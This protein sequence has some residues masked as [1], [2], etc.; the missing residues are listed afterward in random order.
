[1]EK[2]FA[3]APEVAAMLELKPRAIYGGEA[4]TSCLQKK[5]FGA[6]PKWYIPQVKA[7]LRNVLLE[8]ACDGS[9]A[10]VFD[11]IQQPGEPGL[12]LV[13]PVEQAG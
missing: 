5:Y 4:G 9:C 1:M 13:P 6:S 7:H 2:Q 10:N 12:K 11:Q 3:T 8:G